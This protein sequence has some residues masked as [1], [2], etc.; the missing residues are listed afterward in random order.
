MEP[1]K[2]GVESLAAIFLAVLVFVAALHSLQL[3]ALTKAVA[4]Q[5]SDLSGLKA[6]LLAAYQGGGQA[7]ATAGQAAAPNSALPKNLQSLPNMVG[8]C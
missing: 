6:T 8:G 4:G 2:L 1:F 3:T 5:Q 7:V